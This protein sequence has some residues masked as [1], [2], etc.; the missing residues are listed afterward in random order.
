MKIEKNGQKLREISSDFIGT[1]LIEN[2]STFEY[3]T[4]I[5]DSV[6]SPKILKTREVIKMKRRFILLVMIVL[7]AFFAAGCGRL[8][9]TPTGPT[10][11]TKPPFEEKR[12]TVKVEYIRVDVKRPDLMGRGAFVTIY[13]D[14]QGKWIV[15]EFLTRKDDYH[16]EKT[17]S[18]ILETESYNSCY[19]VYTKDEARWDGIDSSTAIVGDIFIFTTLREDGSVISSLKLTNILQNNLPSNPYQGPNAR[20]AK[21]CIHRDGTLTNE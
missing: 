5:S 18:G 11:P 13:D 8:G 3:I 4:N 21:V 16:F 2:N 7:M 12:F 15:C 6:W 20:M 1:K 19:F 9:E 14:N 17:Y 10:D